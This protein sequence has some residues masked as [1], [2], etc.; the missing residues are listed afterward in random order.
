MKWL[1]LHGFRSSP[2]SFKA[3][4]LAQTVAAQRP[5]DDWTCPALPPSPAAAIHLAQAAIATTSPQDLVIVGSSLGGYYA[6]WLAE[7]TGARAAVINPVVDAAGALAA[8]VG[9]QFM[10]HDGSPFEFQPHYLQELEHLRVRA[11]TQPHRYLLLAATGDELLDWRDMRDHYA[12]A[13]QIIIEGSDHG[14]SDFAHWLPQVLEF[15]TVG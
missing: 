14:L 7:H 5:A 3:R 10:Y 9:P 12:G 4:L 15:A 13:R 8:H 11:I 6:T 1:Y 2:E